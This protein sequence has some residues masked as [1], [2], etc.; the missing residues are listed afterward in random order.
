MRTRFM[1]AVSNEAVLKAL[2]KMKSDD[3]TFTKAIPTAAEIEY[4]AKVAKDTVYGTRPKPVLKLQD[5]K[6]FKKTSASTPSA[7]ACLRCGKK[8]HLADSC[9]HK[10]S[11]CNYCHKTGHLEVVC[12]KKKRDHPQKVTLI[13]QEEPSTVKQIQDLETP[14]QRLQLKGQ[15][16]VFEVDTGA[17]DNFCSEDVWTSLGRPSL[18]QPC[19]RYYS[20][21][22]GLLPVQ[23]VFSTPASTASGITE[24]LDFN[25]SKLPLNLLGRRAIQQ[26]DIDVRVLLSQP[27]LHIDKDEE[28]QKACEEV[29][30]NFPD[31]FCPELGCLKDFELDVRFKPDAE[32]RFIKPRRNT[33]RP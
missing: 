15:T 31:L 6:T 1:C 14:K 9:K 28:L 29:C 21:T 26:M 4:A 7:S 27:V 22:G 33:R 10:N 8:N 25:V 18:K 5:K 20:A 17:R 32:P 12:F 24:D 19:S 3:L 13:T 2:F 23:G 30:Q 11:E 16:F